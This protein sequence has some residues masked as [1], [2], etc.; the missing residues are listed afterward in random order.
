MSNNSFNDAGIE[1]VSKFEDGSVT[2]CLNKMGN[3]IVILTADE[4]VVVLDLDHK[5]YNA[6]HR[7][8]RHKVSL[9]AY[10]PDNKTIPAGG[11]PLQQLTAEVQTPETIYLDKFDKQER[12]SKQ[13]ADHQKLM[14]IHSKLTEPQKLVYDALTAN[15]GRLKD[16]ELATQLNMSTQNFSNHKRSLFKKIKK[17]WSKL[18]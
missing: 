16:K 8:T 13:M 14:A 11:N 17:V 7:N 9:D 18:V 1:I 10:D 2:V 5:Q 4:A 15:E 6:D 12:Q 3:Q